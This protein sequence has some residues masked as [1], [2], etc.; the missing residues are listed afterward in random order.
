MSTICNKCLHL[1]RCN[2]KYYCNQPTYKEKGDTCKYSKT[3]KQCSCFEKGK[4]VKKYMKTENNSVW[5]RKGK[6][7]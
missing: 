1:W 6:E 4:N 3:K 7:L 5:K 2:R